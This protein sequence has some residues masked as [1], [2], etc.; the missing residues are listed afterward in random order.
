MRDFRGCDDGH[1]NF[2]VLSTVL[3]IVSKLHICGVSLSYNSLP[4]FNP[5]NFAQALSS[6]S[7]WPAVIPSTAEIGNNAYVKL[8]KKNVNSSLSLVWASI[9][10]I[11]R[12]SR[13][14][15]LFIL[16]NDLV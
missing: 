13:D 1:S 11:L 2:Q 6:I 3:H 5:L 9:S 10:H 4:L 12:L 8:E 7:L 15:L 16:V 14:H